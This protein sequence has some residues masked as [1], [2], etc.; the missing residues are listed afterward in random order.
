MADY[1][2]ALE[3]DQT[4]VFANNGRANILFDWKRYDEALTAYDRAIELDPAYVIARTNRANTL[5]RLK[6]FEEA[7]AEYSRAIELD[8]NNGNIYNARGNVYYN[9]ERYQE[10]IADFEHAMRHNPDDVR[11]ISSRGNALTKLGRYD[12]AIADLEAAIEMEPDLSIYYNNLAWVLATGP[13]AIRDPQRALALAERS[14]ALASPPQAYHF[15]TYGAAL[16][17]AGRTDAA[18]EQYEKSINLDDTRARLYREDLVEK[19]YLAGPISDTR[20]E[21]LATAIHACVVDGCQ[22]LAP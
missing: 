12:E 11:P 5:R 1:E 20:E 6:R 19:G 9:K 13:D 8:A 22:L 4:H 14:V 10:A 16:V 3:L 7:L 17:A 21:A 2:R 18:I 15:G